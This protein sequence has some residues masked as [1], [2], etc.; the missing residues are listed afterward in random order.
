MRTRLVLALALL[1]GPRLA[2][3]EPP[4]KVEAITFKIL[5]LST[6]ALV[7][8]DDKGNDPYGN[9][10]WVVVMVKVSGGARKVTLAIT[11]P[12]YGDEATGDHAAVHETHAIDVGSGYA[13]YT[14]A[15]PCRTL[16]FKA[17]AGTSTKKV[18]GSFPCAE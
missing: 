18:E 6:G 14:L 9:D 11:A 5:R 2:R 16:T 17:S 10:E 13:L 12:A 15:H 1:L 8:L 3:A 4:A 7:A